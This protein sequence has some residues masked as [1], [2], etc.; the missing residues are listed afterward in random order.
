MK[1]LIIQL[2]LLCQKTHLF[3]KK[4]KWREKFTR[5]TFIPITAIKGR[6]TFLKNDLMGFPGFKTVHQ[7]CLAPTIKNLHLA[8]ACE[9]RERIG[10]SITNSV[11]IIMP[12][13]SLDNSQGGGQTKEKGKHP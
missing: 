3:K 4:K 7:S 9:K 6:K 13:L 12:G 1:R 2:P 8:N 10:F 11:G 5:I